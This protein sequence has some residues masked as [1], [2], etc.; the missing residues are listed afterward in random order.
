VYEQ[1]LRVLRHIGEY[2]VIGLGVAASAVPANAV[3]VG[4]RAGVAVGAIGGGVVASRPDAVAVRVTFSVGK[5]AIVAV[6]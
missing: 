3:G 1:H 6:A 5:R 4:A 2:I